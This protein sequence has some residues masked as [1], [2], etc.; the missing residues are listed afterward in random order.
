MLNLS[1]VEKFYDSKRKGSCIF[2]D[3][4]GPS[5]GKVCGQKTDS[6]FCDDHEQEGVD[7]EKATGF[8][9]NLARNPVLLDKIL[10]QIAFFTSPRWTKVM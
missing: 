1:E 4:Y 3:K 9:H 2:V 10:T 5:M 6:L 7:K 8:L